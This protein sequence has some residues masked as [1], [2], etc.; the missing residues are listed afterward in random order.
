MPFVIAAPEFISAAASDLANL[1][2]AISEATSTA[3]GPTTG[4]LPAAEDEVSAA[5]AALFGAQAVEFQSLSA[6]AAIFTT[7]SCRP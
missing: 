5:I 2:S 4:V 1:G 7:S 6:K 3:A